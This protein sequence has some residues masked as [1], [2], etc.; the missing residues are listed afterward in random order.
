MDREFQ[1]VRLVTSLNNNHESIAHIE[2]FSDSNL[3]LINS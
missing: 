3:S 1:K 2:Y